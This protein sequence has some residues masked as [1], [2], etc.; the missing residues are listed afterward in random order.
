MVSLFFCSDEALQLL[1]LNVYYGYTL[2][3]VIL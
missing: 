2:K 1:S 3:G